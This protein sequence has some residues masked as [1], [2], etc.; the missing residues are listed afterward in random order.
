[1]ESAIDK[2]VYPP[3]SDVKLTRGSRSRRHRT[4]SSGIAKK[5]ERDAILTLLLLARGE[6]VPLAAISACAHFWGP[7]I[8]ELRQLGFRI[9]SKGLGEPDSWF[10]LESGPTSGKNES[11][12]AKPS[13]DLNSS[14]TTTTTPEFGNLTADGRYPD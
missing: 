12:H 1:M 3:P 6:W 5:K 4:L 7:R 13:A 2:T 11:G 8:H 14:V 10:R 9:Q